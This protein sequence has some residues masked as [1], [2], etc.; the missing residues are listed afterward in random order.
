MASKGYK[1]RTNVFIQ[2]L[3]PHVTSTEQQ[4][5]KTKTRPRLHRN[6]NNKTRSSPNNHHHR[7]VS[8]VTH[9][10][11]T[12]TTRYITHQPT[13]HRW[14]RV[15]YNASMEPLRYVALCCMRCIMLRCVGRYAGAYSVA[16]CKCVRGRMTLLC[17]A[18]HCVAVAVAVTAGSLVKPSQVRHRPRP[19]WPAPAATR[20]H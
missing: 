2:S 7:L 8:E 4:P 18:L 6:T 3:Q 11:M 20:P 14:H 15:H 10:R 1:N 12:R 5:L 17:V 13:T 9:A 19:H 16:S